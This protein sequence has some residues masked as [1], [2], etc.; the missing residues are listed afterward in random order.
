[1]T[2]YRIEPG[3][4]CVLTI[5]SVLGGHPFPAYA[6]TET[7]SR[8]ILVPS[9]IFRKWVDEQPFWRQFAFSTIS[10]RL[11]GIL[12][13]I[14]DITFDRMDRRLARYILKYA[15]TNSTKLPLTHQYIASELGTAREVISRLLKQFESQGI[16]SLARG[17]ITVLDKKN[18]KNLSRA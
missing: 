14:E 1:M 9:P 5:S 11:Y 15:E 7:Q 2:L 17:E 4:T 13:T 8:I 10:A 3:S 18:L 12:C 16:V 6:V